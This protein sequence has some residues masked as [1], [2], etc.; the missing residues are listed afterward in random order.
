MFVVVNFGDCGMA[1]PGAL[2]CETAGPDGCCDNEDAGKTDEASSSSGG[3]V[4]I[5]D[6]E[7]DYEGTND[8]SSTFESGVQSTCY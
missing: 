6:E 3:M 7:T 4:G 1:G 8:G 5:E 2:P